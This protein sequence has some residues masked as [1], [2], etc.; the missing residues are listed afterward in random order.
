[1]TTISFP[2]NPTT[3]QRY[4]AANGV[5]YIWD[6]EKW[7]SEAST[8]GT[9]MNYVL[10]PASNS[11]LGGVKIGAN[12]SVDINGVISVPTQTQVDWN[13]TNASSLDFIKNKPSVPQLP[14]NALGY[15]YNN[16]SG[17]LSWNTPSGSGGTVSYTPATSTDWSGTPPATMQAAI[18]RLAAA[19]KTLN[20]GTGA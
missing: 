19:F 20:N 5:T 9:G 10:P 14:T 4:T 18:D 6:N 7:Q 2:N 13:E 1:M 16:G 12:I 11:Q 8:F 3:G 17:T 15:L